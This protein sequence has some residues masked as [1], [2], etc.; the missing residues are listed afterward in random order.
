MIKE[1][2]NQ[3]RELISV[4]KAR[5]YEIAPGHVKSLM[6]IINEENSDQE[7][8][9]KIDAFNDS[10]PKPGIEMSWYAYDIKTNR[11]LELGVDKQD[12]SKVIL[13]AWIPKR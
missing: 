3:P 4:D 7:F 11:A 2:F 9:D 13:G 6:E 5:L 10:T 12:N 1:K 8:K